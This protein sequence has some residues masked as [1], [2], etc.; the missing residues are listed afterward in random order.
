MIKLSSKK[1]FVSVCGNQKTC[2]YKTRGVFKVAKR[3]YANVIMNG[4]PAN[5]SVRASSE[6]EARIK[7]Q[8][9][10]E[11]KGVSK[12]FDVSSEPPRKHEREEIGVPLIRK[13][14]AVVNIWHGGA[15]VTH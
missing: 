11:F 8:A 4:Q 12:I 14:S 9:G 1:V 2:V 7:L 5:L 15:L 6:K 13:R 3:M 10:G